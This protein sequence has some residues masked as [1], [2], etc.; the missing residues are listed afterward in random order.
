MSGEVRYW[1]L[2]IGW[3]IVCLLLLN[4]W[5]RP[6]LFAAAGMTIVTLAVL[7]VGFGW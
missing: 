5:K 7:A 1:P 3:T 4:G 6:A 2:L